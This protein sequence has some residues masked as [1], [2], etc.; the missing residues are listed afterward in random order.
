MRLGSGFSPSPAE[1]LQTTTS[2][3]TSLLPLNQHPQ[4]RE[5]LTEWVNEW[6][7]NTSL[8]VLLRHLSLLLLLLLLPMMMA[9][10]T[11]KHG[12]LIKL[13]TPQTSLTAAP[14]THP[15]PS[16]LLLLLTLFGV[17]WA[18]I[19]AK[20][21]V[22]VGTFDAAAAADEWWWCQEC[23][24]KWR[25]QTFRGSSIIDRGN[26]SGRI[27]ITGEKN[28]FSL[29]INKG[30]CKLGKRKNIG[31]KKGYSDGQECHCGYI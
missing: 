4:I 25:M 13:T 7:A 31:H 1:A 29:S 28:N 9:A 2:T 11:W 10:T 22:C 14:H 6:R 26:I 3:T 16:P 20:D 5:W 24:K 12:I 19:Y 8:R 27:I 23:Q 17:D 21:I 30:S 18:H 15:E